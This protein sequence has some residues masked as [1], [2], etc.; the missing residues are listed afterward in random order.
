MSHP[1][2]F[3]CV[4]LLWLCPISSAAQE[5]ADVT[6]RAALAALQAASSQLEKAE[7]APDRVAALTASI[8]ALEAGLRSLRSGLRRTVIAEAQLASSLQAQEIEIARFLTVLQSLGDT[9]SPFSIL[10]PEGPTGSARASMLLAELTPALSRRA[11]NLR[12]DLLRVQQLRQHQSDA[13]E[14]LQ[15]SL[16]ELQSARTALSKAAANRQDLPRRFI[17]DPIRMALLIASSDT[18]EDFAG[19]LGEVISK[20]IGLPSEHTQSAAGNLPLPV[21]GV[22]LR[23]AVEADAASVSRPGLLL[24]TRPGAVVVSPSA[25]TIRYAGPLLDFGNVVILEPE[26]DALFVL[27]GLGIVYGKAGQI[28]SAGAPLGLMPYLPSADRDSWSPL[29][30]D[31]GSDLSETLYIEVRWKNAPQ[32]PELWFRSTEDG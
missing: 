15:K 2:I 10:H 4:A 27:A 3:L 14:T 26:A 16:Q 1:L 17:A 18:L 32:N 30:E 24:G 29:R 11:A 20:D 6:A 13:E 22:I 31:T 23:R 25:A 19:G 5:S 28:I 12:A 21:Q 7:Q 9:A 8:R